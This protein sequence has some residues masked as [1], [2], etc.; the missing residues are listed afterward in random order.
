MSIS[1][2]KTNQLKSIAILMMLFLH[3]FNRDYNNLFTP[4]I[5]L[6]EQPLTYYLSLFSDACVPIFAFVSGYGLYYSYSSSSE[7]YFNKNLV[8]TKKL[9]KRYW[10][11]I[12]IFVLTIGS[13]LQVDGY[14]GSLSKLLLNITGLNPTYNGA[15]WFF[16]TYI[17]FIFTS[18]F[19]FKLLDKLNGY[20]L[21]FILLAIYIVSFYF[22]VYQN[23]LFDY[24]LF[25]WIHK[26]SAL[27][28]C[29]LFQFMM[30]AF[31]LKYNWHELTTNLFRNLN[32]RNFLILLG[33][34]FLIFFH[35]L[36]PNFIIAPF[37]GIIFI[38]LFLQLRL[39]LSTN[40]FLDF[41][42]PHATNLWLVHM[43]FYS[44]YFHSFIYSVQYP[45]LIFSLLVICCV[46]SSYLI[47]F[48]YR[49][50][51]FKNTST[52]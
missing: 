2:Q 47:N 1:I 49:A 7:D 24:A 22:R 16:T 9:Y 40:H 36:V 13:L 52:N 30:G 21:F 34:S 39:P 32:Y 29:T 6:G 38:L 27:Y 35:G 15:W 37:T 44:I 20:I 3:L 50:L 42:T 46:A 31:A 23:N 5:F 26:Q 11:I 41:F 43:F 51:S 4:L 10:I 25:N 19:W 12:T 48:I 17:L 14:P 8:R 18:H 33:I 28:F 45:V